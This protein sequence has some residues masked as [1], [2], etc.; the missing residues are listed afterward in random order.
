MN[1]GITSDWTK[2]TLRN[3]VW[4]N[5]LKNTGLDTLDIDLPCLNPP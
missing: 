2:G 3:A 5:T 1:W 4:T